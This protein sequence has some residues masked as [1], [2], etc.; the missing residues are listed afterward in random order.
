MDLKK[1]NQGLRPKGKEWD[2]VSLKMMGECNKSRQAKMMR[3]N[4]RENLA[5]RLISKQNM[6]MTMSMR[7]ENHLIGEENM[8]KRWVVEAVKTT[9]IRRNMMRR[10]KILF[11]KRLLRLY[12]YVK[13][14]KRYLGIQSSL[15]MINHCIKILLIYLSMPRRCPWLNG[16]DLMK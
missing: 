8:M 14:M 3:M 9:R 7:W 5:R 12:K 10:K 15:L 6:L 13:K 1:M 4:H 16:E 11:R 2:M